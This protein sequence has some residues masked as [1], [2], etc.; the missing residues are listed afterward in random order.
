MDSTRINEFALR[1]T[2]AWCSQNAANVASFFAD[3]GSLKINDDDPAVGR[4][5]ISAAAQGFMTAFPDLLVRMDR[6]AIN[7]TR[8]AYHWTLTGTHTGPGGTGRSV[9]ISGFE[10][11]RFDSDGLIAESKGHFDAADYQQQLQGGTQG[12]D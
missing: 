12:S 1:Y 6:L 8:V 11:W 4:I 7:G 10:D 5:A 3:Q 2:A 9:R